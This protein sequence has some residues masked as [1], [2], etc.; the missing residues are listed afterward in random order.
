MMLVGMGGEFV[1]PDG[2]TYS[3]SGRHAPARDVHDPLLLTAVCLE[4]EAELYVLLNADF[5]YTLAEEEIVAAVSA[6]CDIPREAVFYTATHNHNGPCR[7]DDYASFV[8]RKARIAAREA[9]EGRCDVLVQAARTHYDRIITNRGAPWEPVDGTVAVVRFVA[10]ESGR[11]VAFIWNYACHPCTLS[12]D[13][14]QF[15]ADYPGALRASVQESLGFAVPVVFLT[16][17]SG[18]VQPIGFQRFEVPPGMY[19]NVPKGDMESVERLGKILATAGLSALGESGPGIE[20][21]EVHADRFAVNTPIQFRVRRAELRERLARIDEL[22]PNNSNPA[23]EAFNVEIR[24]SLRRWLHD[25]LA[26]AASEIP[27]RAIEHALLAFGEVA[28][29]LSP[30]E[31][32]WE[33]GAVIKD[34]SPF[35][36]T[37]LGTTSLGYEGYLAPSQAYELPLE[38]FPYHARGPLDLAGFCYSAESAAA[39][40]DQIHMKLQEVYGESG[41]LA[42]GDLV[43]PAGHHRGDRDMPRV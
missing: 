19:M 42:G 2:R 30:L 24:R 3:Y 20:L 25:G 21:T 17:C 33:I 27:Q 11:P 32:A 8:V 29:V 13:F 9:M 22:V 12:S 34:R 10:E 6:E 5:L 35:S 26:V 36:H 37:I 1:G 7:T 4:C 41:T 18:N 14:N 31:L 38:E 43:G 15:S 16:G 40:V 39:L 23:M 28:V